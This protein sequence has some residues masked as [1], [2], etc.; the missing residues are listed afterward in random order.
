MARTS[1]SASTVPADQPTVRRQRRSPG[2]VSTLLL[3]ASRQLFSAN[4]YAGTSTRQIADQAG[5]SEALLFR[6]FG[7]KA[8]LFELAMLDPFNEFVSDFMDIWR[9]QLSNP[10]PT[11]VL[12]RKFMTSLYEMMREHRQLFLALISAQAFDEDAV[13]DGTTDSELTRQIDR[14]SEFV[15]AEATTRPSGHLDHRVTF[16]AIVGM[17][18]ALSVL[19]EWLLPTGDRRPN[20]EHILDEVI[21]LSLYG[22]IGR[23]PKPNE[24]EPDP[25]PASTKRSAARG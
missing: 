24:V 11:A 6:H 16:R 1:N 5:V 12:F 10:I 3:T 19:D 22:M 20:D 2:E 18:I 8:K 7:T 4:G 9:S 17:V 25:A 14:F 21:Q 23:R 15:E 13:D